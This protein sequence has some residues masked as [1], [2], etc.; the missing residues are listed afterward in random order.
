M[1]LFFKL[2]AKIEECQK[3]LFY[4]QGYSFED[5][6]EYTKMIFEETGL[7]F[8]LFSDVPKS[9]LIDAINYLHDNIIAK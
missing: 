7:K 6:R 4:N 3:H 5:A 2:G 1:S 8:G 9:D